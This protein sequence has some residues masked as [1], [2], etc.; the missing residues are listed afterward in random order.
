[1]SDVWPP[2]ETLRA[3]WRD[4][5]DAETFFDA[6][7]GAILETL[8]A[9]SAIVFLAHPSG[10]CSP[11]RGR[12]RD[13]RL[14]DEDLEDASRSLVER[15]VAEGGVVTWEK[16]AGGAVPASAAAL[17]LHAAAA[18]PVGS[19]VRAVLY[20]DFRKLTG[21]RNLRRPEV[22][23]EA[24]ALVAEVVAPHDFKVSPPAAAAAA[25]PRPDLDALLTLPGLYAM[26]P[27]IGVALAN[28]APVL[29]LGE[30]G[31]GKTLLAGALARRL[32]PRGKEPVRAM[33]GT[34]DDFN[35]IVSELFG[36]VKGAYSGA[37]GRRDGLVKQAHGGVLILDE[38][39]N[40]PLA[41]QQLLLDFTQ[42]GEYRPLGHREAA[43]ERA[44]VRLIAVTNGDLEAAVRERRFRADLYHRLAGTVLHVPP[45]RERR[46]DIPGL[47]S[48]LLG[49]V[50][51]STRWRLSYGARRALRAERLAWEGNVRQFELVLRRAV[52][53]ARREPGDVPE[54]IA[55][56]HLDAELLAA[57]AAKLSVP[58]PAAG[59]GG[60]RGGVKARVQSLRARKAALAQEEEA[61]ITAALEVCGGSKREAAALLEMEYTT[62]TS[63]LAKRRGG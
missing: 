25:P 46:G 52:E 39:L 31:S 17:D 61:L 26:A 14:S 59:D 7:F 19:P 9:H 42:F 58:P 8:Q 2:T 49:H 16:H 57:P 27:A 47:A 60:E 44:D 41:A 10:A 11:W 33:L 23:R 32:A 34:A 56:A 5:A 29:V 13:D 40:L 54:E 22:F 1:M 62:L 18:A 28:P 63:R 12:D 43:P 48:I 50:D 30:T 4:R 55:E 45:L 53:R 24:A 37:D 21:M 15:C 20:V 36:H 51:P 38:V 6:L 35:T 3:L